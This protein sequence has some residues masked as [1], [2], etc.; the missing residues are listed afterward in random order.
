MDFMTGQADV[1]SSMILDLTSDQ[2]ILAQTSPPLGRSQLGQKLEASIVYC[3]LVTREITRW[4]WTATVLDLD[5]KYRLH[6]YDES[7]DQLV[8]VIILDRPKQSDLSKS[9]VRQAYR[10][11]AGQSNG[12]SVTIHPELSPISLVNF[13]AGGFML[14]TPTPT[15]YTLGQELSFKMTFPAEADLPIR[16]LVGKAAIVRLELDPD[17]KTAH[18]GLKFHELDPEAQRALPK[19]LQ[20]YMLEEQRNRKEEYDR[21]LNPQRTAPDLDEF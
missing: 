10:L 5:N 15:S 2:V 14:S 21:R 12:I 16:H 8:P 6:S 18:L 9:N 3:D 1:R 17:E 13:S 7:E 4:G 19:I 11:E 20:Y